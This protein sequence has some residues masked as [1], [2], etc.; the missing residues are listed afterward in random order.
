M[1]KAIESLPLKYIV[2]IITAAIIIS[3][4]LYMTGTVAD[5]ATAGTE[6]ANQTLTTV[7]NQSLGNALK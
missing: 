6:Q 3:T 4:I 1:S 2:M 7:L 5:L